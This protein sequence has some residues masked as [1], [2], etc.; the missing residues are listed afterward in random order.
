MLHNVSKQM[1]I[2][3][4]T[5]IYCV[6]LTPVGDNITTVRCG[7]GQYYRGHTVSVGYTIY[8]ST[9]FHFLHMTHAV[10][11]ADKHGLTNEA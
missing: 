7:C 5:Y 1:V 10:D 8:G 3:T 2:A 6:L 9:A 4:F 11:I